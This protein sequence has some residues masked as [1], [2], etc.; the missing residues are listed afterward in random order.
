[1]I[2]MISPLNSLQEYPA[3]SVAAKEYNPPKTVSSSRVEVNGEEFARN[4]LTCN[5]E[6]GT[7]NEHI[8]RN[9]L[10]QVRVARLH[11]DRAYGIASRGAMSF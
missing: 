10:Y 4:W 5:Y 6:A 11:R 7:A 3:P 9:T 8:A 1:M 2:Y